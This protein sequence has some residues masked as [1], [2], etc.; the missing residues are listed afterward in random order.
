M[1]GQIT[2]GLADYVE[3][4]LTAVKGWGFT[5]DFRSPQS[6]AE[7]AR[8]APDAARFLR[9]RP[10]SEV[11]GVLRALG[12]AEACMLYDRLDARAAGLAEPPELS[13]RIY[14]RS[15]KMRLERLNSGPV[16][17]EH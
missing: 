14:M 17:L 7:L 1:T 3:P 2:T 4:L 11:R 10:G 9:Y 5:P 12:E 6:L 15:L 13:S 16:A 8:Q